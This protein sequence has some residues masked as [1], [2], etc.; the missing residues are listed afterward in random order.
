MWVHLPHIDPPRW[1]LANPPWALLPTPH[2]A[3]PWGRH[4][5]PVAEPQN[6]AVLTCTTGWGGESEEAGRK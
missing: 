6:L 3:R 2:L 1:G 5:R 4:G